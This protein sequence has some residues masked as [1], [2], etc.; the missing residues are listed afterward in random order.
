MEFSSERLILDNR[1]SECAC[2]GCA[3]SSGRLY[4]LLSQL[5][6]LYVFLYGICMDGTFHATGG[7]QDSD[8]FQKAIRMAL[9]LRCILSVKCQLSGTLTWSHLVFV[10]FACWY[11]NL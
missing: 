8:V 6:L 2:P 5:Q 11:L 10:L 3:M 9:T 4:L 1:Y 7:F